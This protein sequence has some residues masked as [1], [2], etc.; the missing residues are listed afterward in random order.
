MSDFLNN[1]SSSNYNKQDKKIINK[2]NNE[3]KESE[4][5]TN[6][7]FFDA[8]AN[9][10][11]DSNFDG[12]INHE[13]SEVCDDNSL[14]SIGQEDYVYDK[15]Y[16]KNLALKRMLMIISAVVCFLLVIVVVLFMFLTTVPE[17]EKNKT[18]DEMKLWA[19]QN[20]ITL[21]I[22]EQ[23]SLEDE[24]NFVISQNKKPNSLIL[25]G[26]QID[27]IVSKGADPDQL[28]QLPDFKKMSLSEI[29]AWKLENRADN[30]SII[31]EFSSEV[32]KDSVISYQIKTQGV[33]EQS[34]TRKDRLT[35]VISKGVEIFEKNIEVPD[36][37]NA[38]KNEVESWAKQNSIDVIY[39]EQA[40]QT[41]IEGAIISQSIPAKE[42]IAKNDQFTVVVSVGRV[43]HAPNFYGLSQDDAL[44]LSMQKGV[45]ISIVEKYSNTHNAGSLISQSTPPHYQVDNNEPIII[46]TYSI[47]LPYINDYYGVSHQLAIDAIN[48]M[49]AKGAN[50]TYNINTIQDANLSKGFVIM[51]SPTNGY[52]QVGSVINIT[53]SNGG[54]TVIPDLVGQMILDETTVA[55]I[56]RLESQ[57]LRIVKQYVPNSNYAPG[58]IFEQSISPNQN[59]NT[60]ESFL[61]IKIAN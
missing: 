52:V 10:D 39:Q 43:L 57:G 40:S 61:V 2:D 31:K 53:I 3:K 23:Y 34:Y 21:N 51:L 20:R 58:T 9:Q 55:L 38:Q 35:I 27:V 19:V 44:A 8:V 1:F 14:S 45:S 24:I 18:I 32:E 30:V 50:L 6:E 28:I 47:G 15:E 13:T 59:V 56:T 17:F 29:E 26:S 4:V 16:A 36:F 42:K 11:Q 46:L 5:L 33:S 54:S 60:S 25:K 41:V 49:N 22:V 37:V 12:K 48:E 7:S